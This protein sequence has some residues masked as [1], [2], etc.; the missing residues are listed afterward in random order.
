M[1]K[2]DQKHEMQRVTN[3]SKSDR[4]A[5]DEEA[6][7]E[8]DGFGNNLKTKTGVPHNRRPSSTP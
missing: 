8:T 5:S 3:I 1:S 2:E 6:N 7:Y 4:E